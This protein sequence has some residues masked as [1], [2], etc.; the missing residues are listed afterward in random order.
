MWEP[1]ASSEVDA[2]GRGEFSLDSLHMELQPRDP[3]ADQSLTGPGTVEQDAD[4]RLR[5]V[6]F[7]RGDVDWGRVGLLGLRGD[8]AEDDLF[9]LVLRDRRGREWKATQ[10]L[11][12]CD[13][14]GGEGTV[15][16]GTIRSLTCTE[17]LGNEEDTE[18]ADALAM[19]FPQAYDIPTTEGTYIERREEGGEVRGKRWS[20]N[21]WRF[22][23]GGLQFRFKQNKDEDTL[24]GSILAEENAGIP[25]RFDSRVEEALWVVLFDRPLWSALFRRSGR[26]QSVILEQ[27]RTM[28]AKPRLGP[29]TPNPREPQDATQL[30]LRYLDYLSGYSEP[31]YHPTSVGVRRAI[32]ASSRAVDSEARELAIEVEGILRRDFAGYGAPGEDELEQVE[33]VE[34]YF[35]DF[36]GPQEMQRRVD[37]FINGMRDTHVVTALKNLVDEGRISE[38]HRSVWEKIR[39]DTAHGKPIDR[40][41]PE[42]V[43]LCDRLQQLLYFLIFHAVGYEGKYVHRIGRESEVRDFPPE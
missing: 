19:L 31:R 27:P 40:P 15:C 26:K 25:P 41:I 10:I 24:H 42:L 11:P 14:G 20:R 16:R 18:R 34:D 37:G 38:E 17:E 30:F 22:Q 28:P 29:V 5:F 8:L 23:G 35:E 1:L 36:D 32:Q 43:T 2:Y 21:I 3:A 12:H 6:L 33:A 9:D 4:G 7:H 13:L 39:G